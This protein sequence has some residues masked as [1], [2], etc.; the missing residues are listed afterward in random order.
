MV[1]A[2]LSPAS[3]RTLYIL[4][5][6]A[7]GSLWA[8]YGYQTGADIRLILRDQ[9]TLDHYRQHGGIR[10]ISANQSWLC[11]I[12]ADCP[13]SISTPI[14]H[15]LITTKTQQTLDALRSIKPHI[16]AQAVMVLLQNGLGIVEQIRREFPNATVLQGSTTEAC[17]QQ[18]RFE[19]VHAGHGHTFIG[20]TENDQRTVLLELAESL[21]F[22]PLQLSVSDNIDAVLWRKLAI[23]CV[24]N[25]LTVIH[26]CRNGELLNSPERRAQIQQIVNEIL[27][28]SSV[29]GR[30]EW[31][32]N[33][34]E[35]V[36]EVATT[37]AANRSSM[38][39][40]VEAG[41][42]TEI[43][44]ITGYVCQ[45]AEQHNTPAPMNRQLLDDIKRLPKVT[46]C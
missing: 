20:S 15:L 4:G 7:I 43:D 41:R 26:R 12:P 16:A 33:L 21:S 1:K 28:L 29:L 42:D 34:Y 24:I 32:A 45:L 40:D 14:Q 46:R 37:T 36:T 22:P 35:L 10:L 11:P 31:V 5:A 2:S 18:N 3:E 17:Y 6:G 30:S 25:P 27:A 23:N 38:L 8:A 9:D 39:Q 13:E 19:Y 44:A